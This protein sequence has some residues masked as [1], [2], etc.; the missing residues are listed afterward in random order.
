MQRR[1]FL[2]ALMAL[3]APASALAQAADAPIGRRRSSSGSPTPPAAQTETIMLR[4]IEPANALERAFM[5]AAQDETMR[6]A[7]RRALLDSQ[8]AVATTGTGDNVRPLLVPLSGGVRAA[9]IF[10]SPQRI[11]AVMGENAPM[12]LMTGREA[13]MRLRRQHIV[14]NYRLMPMLTLDPDD[15]QHFLAITT[16]PSQ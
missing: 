2:T 5:A 13:L 4:P 1:V 16:E 12:L 9:A 11:D 10:T 8:V 7:F 15:V 14:I 3:A 6:P